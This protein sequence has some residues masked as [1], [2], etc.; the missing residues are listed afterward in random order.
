MS[1]YAYL[2]LP[3]GGTLS[4]PEAAQA[5]ADI[6]AAHFRHLQRLQVGQLLKLAGVGGQANF[7]LVLFEAESSAMAEAVM[8]A[9]PLVSS[10]CMTAQC[11]PFQVVLQTAGV[12]LHNA[13]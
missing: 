9:D 12:Q 2:L 4:C 10:G 6:L 1:L 11:V 3:V 13:A 5:E 8:N 7:G